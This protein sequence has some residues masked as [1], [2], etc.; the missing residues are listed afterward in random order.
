MIDIEKIAHVCHEANRALQVTAG[1]SDVSPHFM[2]APEWQVQSAYEGV[3][4][5]LE[6]QTPEQLHESWCA[7]KLRDGWVYGPTKDAAAKTHPCLVPYASLPADQRLKD[8]VFQAI[9]SGFVAAETEGHVEGVM[10]A[11]DIPEGTDYLPGTTEPIP[12][13]YERHYC[14]QDG[15][16][17]PCWTVRQFHGSGDPS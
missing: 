15:E 4:A 7:A 16:E 13:D 3:A 6:G 2:E 10:Y 5:A 12:D 11:D 9:V 14:E 8:A 17:W 1:E